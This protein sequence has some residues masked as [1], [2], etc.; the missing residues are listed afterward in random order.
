MV[1][2]V[3]ARW[4]SMTFYEYTHS[5]PTANPTPAEVCSQRALRPEPA[6]VDEQAHPYWFDSAGYERMRV[7]RLAIERG[8]WTDWP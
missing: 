4:W 1:T 5:T 2:R 8:F 7:V 6:Q 3:S